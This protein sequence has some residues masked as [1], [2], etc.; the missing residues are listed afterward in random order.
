MLDRQ[1]V[2]QRT[3]LGRQ[4]I[5]HKSHGLT[6][7]ERL[8]LILVDGIGEL[9]MIKARLQGLTDERFDRAV[10]KL[11]ASHLIEQVLLQV[12]SPVYEEIDEEV[13]NRFLRQDPLDPVTII[14][15]EPEEEFPVPAAQSAPMPPMPPTIASVSGNE[16]PASAAGAGGNGSPRGTVETDPGTHPSPALQPTGRTHGGHVAASH[17][18][19]VAARRPSVHQ[20]SENRED[21]FA[22]YY[23][24]GLLILSV[25][26]SLTILIW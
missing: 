6:Q 17:T 25:L 22:W 10:R 2:Y 5:R 8:I 19:G 3:D 16:L 23:W 14:S 9:G 13:A 24:V 7:S 11:L 21:T 1:A 15:F 26:T 12:D 20:V 4:E 18:P